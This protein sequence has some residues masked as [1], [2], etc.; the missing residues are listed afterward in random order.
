MAYCHTLLVTFPGQ[1]QINPALQLAKSLLK[2]GVKKVTFSTS[3]SATRSMVKLAGSLPEDLS[4][5]PFSDGYDS[6]FA[7]GYDDI[8]DFISSLIS[9]GSHA[10]KELI[11][12]KANE[13]HPITHVVYTP[14]MSWVLK[15]CYEY[16]ISATFF[17]IQP[18]AV[19]DIYFYYFNGYREKIENFMRGDIIELTWLPLLSDCDLPS[20]LLD[21]SPEVNRIAVRELKDHLQLLEKE[22]NAT[23][24]VNS[25]DG[26]EYEALRA[27]KKFKMM[28]IGPLVPS[29]FLDGKYPLGVSFGGDMLPT[30]KDYVKWMNSKHEGSLVY[31]AFGSY[32]ELSMKQMEQ[33]AHGLLESQKTFLWVIR[34]SY[35]GE[36]LEEKL[37]CKD[38]LEKQGMIVPWCSQMEVLSHPCVGCFVTHCGWNSSLE[39]MVAGVPVVAVPLWNDQATNAKFIQDV[40][41]IGVRAI[42]ND[43]GVFEANEI[44]RCIELVMDGGKIGEEMRINAKKWQGLAREAA[45]DGGPS[46]MNLRTFVNELGDGVTKTTI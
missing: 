4:I 25:F 2:M 8:G 46:N 7:W 12:A 16:G 24:L 10:I 32:S 19:L 26:L 17:W 3:I 37:S 31:V 13:C 43:G 33:I 9:N 21:P 45:K 27:M 35:S 34:T 6:G 44:K 5:V 18:A 36:K 40:W 41:K 23:I 15:I 11:M 29:E 20:F 1:G 22:E 14:F 42:A 39:S 28:A 30:L 38:E